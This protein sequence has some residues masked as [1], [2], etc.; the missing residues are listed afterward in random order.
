MHQINCF[1]QICTKIV[2]NA[3]WKDIL[4]QSSLLTTLHSFLNHHIT[5]NTITSVW[6]CILY[7]SILTLFLRHFSCMLWPFSDGAIFSHVY[8]WKRNAYH[9]AYHFT[10]D[11]Y[12]LHLTSSVGKRGSYINAI[13]VPVSTSLN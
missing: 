4:F 5:T 12:V 10:V 9:F 11:K 7:D 8:L 1:L 13:T 6:Y 2:V 3:K